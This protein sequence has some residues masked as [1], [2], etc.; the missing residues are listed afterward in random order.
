LRD[1]VGVNVQRP[2]GRKEKEEKSEVK[3]ERKRAGERSRGLF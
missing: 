3:T 2:V 1:R